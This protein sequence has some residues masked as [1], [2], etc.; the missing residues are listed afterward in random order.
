MKTAEKA[1]IE[2][3]RCAVERSIVVRMMKFRGRKIVC[4]CVNG[5]RRSRNELRDFRFYSRFGDVECSVN[6]NL[7]CESRVLRTLR[8]SDGRLMEDDINSLHDLRYH[9]PVADITFHNGDRS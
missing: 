4:H 5:S 1:F 6:K 9:L 3:F 8:D 2:R 7:K